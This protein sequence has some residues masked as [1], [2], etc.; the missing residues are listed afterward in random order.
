MRKKIHIIPI[1]SI[2][3]Q[4]DRVLAR[5]ESWLLIGTLMLMILIGFL[6]VILRNLFT[7]GILWGDV[8]LRHLVLWVGFLGASLATRE[9][10]HIKIDALAR[11]LSLD[12]QKRFYRVTHL[13]S[14]CIVGLLVR[15]AY[16]FIRD[17]RVAGTTLFLQIPLWLFVS[18][19]LIA[20]V[21]MAFR[22]LIH[23]FLPLP[24]ET[25]ISGSD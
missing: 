17:E 7:S 22:F 24:E 6:Q 16:V 4:L 18:I 8:F 10:R 15:A 5:V 12:W 25:F 11:R 9:N 20:L 19:I 3:R 2:I 13:F 23:T 1:V 21:L 14:A